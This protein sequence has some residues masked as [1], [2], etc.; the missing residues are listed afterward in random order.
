MH[1]VSRQIASLQCV[2]NVVGRDM[3]VSLG[4]LRV[5]LLCVG[6][7]IMYLSTLSTS[8]LQL[9]VAAGR[10]RCLTGDN[11]VRPIYRPGTRAKSPR[12]YSA[13][14]FLPAGCRKAANCRY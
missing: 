3:P 4:G 6:S 14:R 12:D 11:S 9:V 2:H 13:Q 7:V 10:L 1:G 5:C 8:P